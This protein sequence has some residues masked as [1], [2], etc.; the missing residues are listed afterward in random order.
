MKQKQQHAQVDPSAVPEEMASAAQADS[1]NQAENLAEQL[2]Q[3]QQLCDQKEEAYRRALADY[4][5]LRRQNEQERQRLI[6]LAGQG[7]ITDLLPILDHLEMAAE[8]LSDPAVLM[9]RDELRRTLQQ[10][11]LTPLTVEAGQE[12][13]HN[14]MEVID[15]QPG[16]P[17]QVLSVAQVGYQL[18]GTVIRHAKV[19]V[20]K[21]NKK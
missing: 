17:N 18:N 12:F 9:V 14:L 15:I 7:V 1:S 20:G 10:H 6:Q 8:H 4:Q 3:L 2:A 19:I 5:N 16:S 13:D 11:G 21:A